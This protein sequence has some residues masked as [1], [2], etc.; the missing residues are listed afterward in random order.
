MKLVSPLSAA[1][2][3]LGLLSRKAMAANSIAAV[4]RLTKTNKMRSQVLIVGSESTSCR[5]APITIDQILVVTSQRSSP[6]IGAAARLVRPIVCSC[7][8]GESMKSLLKRRSHNADEAR[9]KSQQVTEARTRNAQAARTS[10]HHGYA[11]LP[12]SNDGPVHLQSQRQDQQVKEGR[13][14]QKAESKK[15]RVYH[16]QQHGHECHQAEHFLPASKVL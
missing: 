14:S 16:D 7:Q 11:S 12:R 1:K 5:G 10:G 9:E 15:V 3:T 2:N 8:R 13:I 6:L 4:A